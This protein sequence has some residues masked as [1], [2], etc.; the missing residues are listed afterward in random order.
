MSTV[1]KY[2]FKMGQFRWHLAMANK[3]R[4]GVRWIPLSSSWRMAPGH[5]SLLMDM[6]LHGFES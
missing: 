4:K 6:N 1:K 2:F 3:S 5:Y